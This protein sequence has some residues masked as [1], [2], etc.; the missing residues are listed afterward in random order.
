MEAPNLN[1]SAGEI[2]SS[3]LSSAIRSLSDKIY[4]NLKPSSSALIK[5][6]IQIGFSPNLGSGAYRS[7][8]IITIDVSTSSYLDLT[9]SYLKFRFG[10]KYGA[11]T[12]GRLGA[13]MLISRFRLQSS[14]GAVIE[15]IQRSNVWAKMVTDHTVSNEYRRSILQMGGWWQNNEQFDNSQD[16]TKLDVKSITRATNGNA[17][18]DV[19]EATTDVKMDVTAVGQKSDYTTATGSDYHKFLL[20]GRANQ[21]TDLPDGSG[22][23][24]DSPT[25]ILSLPLISGF[26]KV[27]NYIPS[28]LG[29]LKFEF[30]LEKASQVLVTEAGYAGLAGGPEYYIDKIELVCDCINISDYLHKLITELSQQGKLIIEY[31]T[32]SNN[33]ENVTIANGSVSHTISKYVGNMKGVYSYFRDSEILNKLTFNSFNSVRASVISDIQWKIG[34]DIFPQAP[35]QNQTEIFAYSCLKA[36]NKFNEFLHPASSFL[37]FLCGGRHMIGVDFEKDP[38]SGWTGINSK[39]ARNIVLE[40]K[41]NFTNGRLSSYTTNANPATQDLSNIDVQFFILYT[42]TMTVLPNYNIIFSE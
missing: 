4:Y 22:L 42:R 3:V 14:S 39:G 37:Q 10:S 33:M 23:N 9:N 41:T 7:E 18:A 36:W 13:E 24:G 5:S 8:G 29:N 6:R 31:D 2:E 26:C 35:L 11:H 20:G 32:L 38:S 34:T 21:S 30:T 12:L 28:N 16:I 25:L 15:D 17:P 1:F 40:Y 19:K 27:K